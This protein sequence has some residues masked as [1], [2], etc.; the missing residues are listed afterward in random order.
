MPLASIHR[1]A[2]NSPAARMQQQALLK[3]ADG[4]FSQEPQILLISRHDATRTRLSYRVQIQL[5]T[6][7][8]HFGAYMTHLELMR[9][10]GA[11][12]KL[13][14][15]WRHHRIKEALKVQLYLVQGPLEE[16]RAI[17]QQLP[18]EE[19]EAISYLGRMERLDLWRVGMDYQRAYDQWFMFGGH[20]EGPEP[21][22]EAQNVED[23]GRNIGYWAGEVLDEEQP[24]PQ[25]IIN[26]LQHEAEAER[27]A[28]QWEERRVQIQEF[29][30]Q[31]RE[32]VEERDRQRQAAFEAQMQAAFDAQLYALAQDYAQAQQH[33]AFEAQEQLEVQQQAALDAHQ[34][35]QV[36]RDVAGAYLAYMMDD[37]EV[38][39]WD[40]GLMD[41]F[42]HVVIDGQLQFLGV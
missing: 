10:P 6:N 5:N 26:H 15:Y 25:Q 36:E 35:E 28:A 1:V 4:D 34:G 19:Y 13:F 37:D 27:Q 38:I 30:Q 7:G 24:H 39:A 18:I 12:D 9:I 29:I 23:L 14:E 16:Y 17:W 32:R 22:Q 40:N 41:P 11:E 42:N 33:A 2:V 31:D 8:K 20:R 3:I 21:A